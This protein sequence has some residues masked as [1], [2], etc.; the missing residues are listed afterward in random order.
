MSLSIALRPRL[1]RRYRLVTLAP[2]VHERLAQCGTSV[3][4]DGLVTGSHVILSVGGV[5][6]Q[7]MAT[8]GDASPEVPPL[9]AQAEVKAK[10]DAGSGFS[11]WYPR[12][13]RGERSLST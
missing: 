4:V 13:H 2:T 12:R 10:Q 11:P 8:G 9:Q 3:Y 6:Y 7:F 5:E 1:E